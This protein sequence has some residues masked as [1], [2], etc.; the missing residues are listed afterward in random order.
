MIITLCVRPGCREILP[1]VTFFTTRSWRILTIFPSSSI[2]LDQSDSRLSGA[3]Y[4]ICL[5]LLVSCASFCALQTELIPR[6]F[7][8]TAL[9]INCVILLKILRRQGVNGA[10]QWSAR[11]A[12]PP[13]T[14]RETTRGNFFNTR[15]W[16]EFLIIFPFSSIESNRSPARLSGAVYNI[17][18]EPST[19]RA[20][21][22]THR[23][24]EEPV[25]K[26]P[27]PKIHIGGF[28][29][30]CTPLRSSRGYGGYPSARARLQRRR[31]VE[32]Q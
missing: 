27:A 32:E 14:P 30:L 2:N 9:G 5:K 4:K 8:F 11:S 1:E 13:W 17:Y 24:V 19:C 18:L 23:G 10:R 12:R 7:S 26:V 31:G 25:P 22:Q 29:F 6:F 20:G 21:S 28:F 15:F 3:A 16:P